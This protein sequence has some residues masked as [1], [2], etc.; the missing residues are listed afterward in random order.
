[1]PANTG[2]RSYRLCPQ[3]GWGAT[4]GATGARRIGL[5]TSR[6]GVRKLRCYREGGGCLR[7]RESAYNTR[8]VW[9]VFAYSIVHDSPSIRART[10]E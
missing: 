8:R 9:R 6:S 1:M 7:R 5:L 4:D 10:R 2:I 3:Y